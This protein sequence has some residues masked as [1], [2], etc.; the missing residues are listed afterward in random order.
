MVK[1][2]LDAP[3]SHYLF[4]AELSQEIDRRTIEE[5]AIDSFTLMEMAG[6]SAAKI[7]LQQKI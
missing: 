6:S 3:Y 2:T 7:L 4:D 1:E 5:M